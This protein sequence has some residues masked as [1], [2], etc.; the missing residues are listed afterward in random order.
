VLRAPRVSRLT[1][2]PLGQ[3]EKAI[4]LESQIEPWLAP[5]DHT[6]CSRSEAEGRRHV[7]E[8]NLQKWDNHGSSLQHVGWMAERIS[9]LPPV[10]GEVF[11]LTSPFIE[12]AN[13]FYP[14]RPMNAAQRRGSLKVH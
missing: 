4:G 7:N 12:R 11:F 5:H 6:A 14:I 1:I 9:P 2:C 3:P 8:M 13:E 10:E